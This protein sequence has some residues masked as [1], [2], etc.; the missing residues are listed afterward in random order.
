METHGKIYGN[1]QGNVHGIATEWMCIILE[2]WMCITGQS[3]YR[4]NLRNP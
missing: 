3:V 2:E 4:T 1:G